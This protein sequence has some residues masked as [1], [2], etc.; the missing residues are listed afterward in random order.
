MLELRYPATRFEV[1]NAAMTGINSH[2]VR[3]IAEDCVKAQGDIWVIYMGNN[4][5]VGPYGAGTVFGSQV[6]PLGLIRASLALKSTR[7]GQLLDAIRG[8]LQPPPPD[9]SDW[10]GMLMFLDQQVRADDPRLSRMYSYFQRN[11]SDIINAGQRAG[12]RMVISTVA[13]NLRD[14]APFASQLQAGSLS[15]IPV[16]WHF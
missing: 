13:V 7:T 11:L 8:W 4:E 12:A 2:A 15:L 14:C 16:F 6:P 1:I 3:A 10:G 5:V 9:K